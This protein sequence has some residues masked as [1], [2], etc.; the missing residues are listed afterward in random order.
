MMLDDDAQVFER[1]FKRVFNEVEY[2]RNKIHRKDGF[3]FFK[4]HTYTVDSLMNS[5][6]HHK[7]DAITEKV[8]D[9]ANNWYKSGK[10]SNVG[11]DHY[12][13]KREEVGDELHSVN[14]EI[15]ARKPTW[16]EQV[17]GAFTG[18]VEA[19][20]KNMPELVRNMLDNVANRLKLP[21]PI[22]KILRLPH[23]G[24]KSIDIDY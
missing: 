17:K 10:L 18:F 1:R 13:R 14:L 23:A 24:N 11:R 3:L 22:R 9:D 12:Y 4:S 6:H 21:S 8:G 15:Q 7:I 16:W 20:A 2:I 5:E 19:I